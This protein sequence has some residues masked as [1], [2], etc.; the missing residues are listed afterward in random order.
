[1]VYSFYD[2][3]RRIMKAR[4]LRKTQTTAEKILW[5]HVRNRQLGGF[6]IRRQQVLDEFI[7]DFYCTEKGLC[8]EVD[9]LYHNDADKR[10]LDKLRDEELE[11]HG[12]TII[13]F[14]NDQV[15]F[16]L[17]RVLADIL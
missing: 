9:G 16:D 10:D 12:F 7:V 1:M 3:P 2:G 5:D 6:K 11:E 13:R 17:D 8:I 14:T 15:L 4:A